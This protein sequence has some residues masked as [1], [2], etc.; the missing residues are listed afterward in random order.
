MNFCTNIHLPLEKNQYKLIQGYVKDPHWYNEPT[1]DKINTSDTGSFVRVIESL[2]RFTDWIFGLASND[3][4][5]DFL[6]AHFL[7]KTYA[8]RD[9]FQTL[10]FDIENDPQETNNIADEHPE[11]VKD[12]LKDIEHYKKEIPNSAPY[13][14]VTD[15]WHDTF[16]TGIFTTFGNFFSKMNYFIHII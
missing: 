2:V 15:N 5:R 12:M 6:S 4:L 11:I 3:P 13:W 16:I 10:L 7:L 14:M 1:E 8:E 9:G